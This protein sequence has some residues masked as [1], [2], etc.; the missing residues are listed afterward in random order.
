MSFQCSLV[1]AKNYPYTEWEHRN[2]LLKTL[3]FQSGQIGP[4]IHQGHSRAHTKAG[5]IEKTPA[6]IRSKVAAEEKQR[7]GLTLEV[8]GSSRDCPG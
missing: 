3:S 5:S 2:I 1:K 6:K 8:G 4:E 7:C